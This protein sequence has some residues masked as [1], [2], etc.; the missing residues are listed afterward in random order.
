MYLND[1][2]DEF[3]LHG[4]EEIDIG[5][6]KLFLLLYA[7]DMTIFAETAEGLQIGLDIYESYCNRWKLTVNIEKTKI[8][9]FRKGDILPRGM[10]FFYNNQ[11]IEKVNSFSYLGIVFTPEDSFSNVNTSLA[12]QAQT[13]VFKLNNYL[14][15]VSD[16]APR[17]VLD[18]FDKLVSSILSYCSELWG[19]CKADKIERVHLQFC[20]TLLG[21][22][23][24][25][26]NTF[27]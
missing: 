6:F 11:E 12:G 2:E 22:K 25:T 10:R 8:M 23:Q 27:I 16:L 14:Y 4:P 20:K 9:V 13:A 26:Q 5:S 7:D 1:I 18:L 19:Y 21:V 17:H 15:S 3:Y 24:S